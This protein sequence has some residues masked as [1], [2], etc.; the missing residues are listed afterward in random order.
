VQPSPFFSAGVTVF[1]HD[2][3]RIRS[4][5]APAGS[6]PIPLVVGNT[7]NGTSDGVE[8]ET[9][10][11]PFDWWRMHAS[12]TT[13]H[14]A[15]TRDPGSRDVSGGNTEA[16]DPS[17]VFGAR[18]AFDLPHNVELDARLRAIGALPNPSV[19]GYTELSL[20]GAWRPRPQLEF[21]V[22]GDDL[23]HDR[24][25]EFIPTARGYEEFERGV[26]AM[27]TVRF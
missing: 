22:I 18:T 26:R 27:L 16:N 3:D 12:L 10:L 11:Q 21:S 9:N 2:Y 1:H 14:L 6:V 4:Q 15:L 24:H 20:R 19:P 13:L 25:P 23:L 8:L 17:Y 5:E 7:L